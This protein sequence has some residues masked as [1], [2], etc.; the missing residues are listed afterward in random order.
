MAFHAKAVQNSYHQQLQP[1]VA[2]LGFPQSR[3]RIAI[4]PG[5]RLAVSMDAAFRA[6]DQRRELPKTFLATGNQF[7]DNRTARRTDSLCSFVFL[8]INS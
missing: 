8:V 4:A 7:I 2:G 1:S 5:L 6:I 3:L